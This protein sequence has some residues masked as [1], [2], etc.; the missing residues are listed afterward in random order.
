MAWDTFFRPAG[1]GPVV[2]R[3]RCSITAEFFVTKEKIQ[4]LPRDFY[5]KLIHWTI[6]SQELSG[7]NSY[8]VGAVLENLWHL[9]FGEPAVMEHLSI[10]EC[11]LYDCSF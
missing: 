9:I 1:F 10:E 11:D 3:T 7:L 6:N 4:S 8:Q 2:E 5:L